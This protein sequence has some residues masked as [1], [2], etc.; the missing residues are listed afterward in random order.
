MEAIDNLDLAQKKVIEYC[1]SA[2][3]M[4]KERE[5]LHAYVSITKTEA[6]FLKQKT[7]NQWLKLGDQMLVSFILLLGFKMLRTLTLIFGMRMEIE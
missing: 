4:L 7:K 6:V 3:C 1:G 5:C 2:D